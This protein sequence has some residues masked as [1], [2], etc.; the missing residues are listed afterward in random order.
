MLYRLFASNL[1]LQDRWQLHLNLYNIHI[2]NIL[3]LFNLKIN[4]GL[5]KEWMKIKIL[6]YCK[7]QQIINIHNFN[8]NTK[9]KLKKIIIIIIIT[10]SNFNNNNNNN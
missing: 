7:I 6:I 10:I 2:N 8:N 9:N 5:I 4:N 1:G 3:N